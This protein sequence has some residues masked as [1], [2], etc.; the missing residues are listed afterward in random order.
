MVSTLKCH[1]EPALETR[2]AELESH[3]IKLDWLLN[4]TSQLFAEL[5]TMRKCK[6]IAQQDRMDALEVQLTLLG[7]GLTAGEVYLEEEMRANLG[8]QLAAIEQQLPSVMARL[9]L[10]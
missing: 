8:T 2:E 7:A 6:E 3:E 1:L 4:G 10:L 9:R 5:T